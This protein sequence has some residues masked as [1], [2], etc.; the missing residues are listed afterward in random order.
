[1]N[2]NIRNKLK[3]VASEQLMRTNDTQSHSMLEPANKEQTTHRLRFLD[4]V[5]RKL[6]TQC[7]PFNE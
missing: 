2:E 5:R 3:T 7:I 4:K 6:Y 1:M